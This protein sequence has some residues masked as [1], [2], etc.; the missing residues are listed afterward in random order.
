[1]SLNVLINY[2]L[3]NK[4]Q[5]SFTMSGFPYIVMGIPARTPT[6][7]VHVMLPDGRIGIITSRP[8]ESCRAVGCTEDHSSHTC[9]RCHERDSKHRTDDCKKCFVPGCRIQDKHRHYCRTCGNADA[10]HYT[11][12]PRGY[13]RVRDV[14]P[15]PAYLRD[16]GIVAVSEPVRHTAMASCKVPGCRIAHPS[17]A[18]HHCNVCRKSDVDHKDEDCPLYKMRDYRKF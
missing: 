6:G 1:M 4:L 3:L 12:V 17:H 16:R 14:V 15:V 9:R 8:K 2:I 13:T 7:G 5:T 18:P 10:D 11:C